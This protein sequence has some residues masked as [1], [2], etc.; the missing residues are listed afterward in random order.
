MW[1]T[2]TFSTTPW[3]CADTE[4]IKLYK[5]ESYI[6]AEVF[7]C[8]NSKEMDVDEDTESYS[9]VNCK[10]NTEV[11]ENVKD[12]WINTLMISDTFNPYTYHEIGSV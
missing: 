3:V 5:S 1:Y 12:F 8:E 4:S 11:D 7:S 6:Y 2:K 10:N 9:E